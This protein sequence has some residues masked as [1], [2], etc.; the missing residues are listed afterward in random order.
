[1][2]G[3]ETGGEQWRQ[4]KKQPRTKRTNAPEEESEKTGTKTAANGGRPD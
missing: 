4:K 2:P 1:M 3:D